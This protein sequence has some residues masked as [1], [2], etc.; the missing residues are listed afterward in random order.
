[1]TQT[2]LVGLDTARG[3]AVFGMMTAHIVLTLDEKLVDGRSSILFGVVAGVSLGLMTAGAPAGRAGRVVRAR[4][5]VRILL[6]ALLVLG[7]GLLLTALEPPVAVILD[8]YGALFILLLPLL[9]APRPVLLAVAAAAA[10]VGPVLVDLAFASLGG[11]VRGDQRLTIV[12]EWL[13][14]G[15]YPLVSWIAFPL[16]GLVVARSDLRRAATRA[17]MAGAGLVA[18]VCG[19]ALPGVLPSTTAEAHSGTTAEILG[20][21]GVALVVLAVTVQLLDGSGPL[22]RVLRVPAWPIAAVGSMPLTIYAIHVVAM[23]AAVHLAGADSGWSADYPGWLLPAN[24][25]G[26]IVVATA[27][28]LALRSGPIELLARRIT[29]QVP[30]PARPAATHPA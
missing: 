3:L 13:L 25:L 29:R 7:I 4:L 10:V 9:F 28:R 22:S 27:F 24:L 30:L 6:R 12:G 11:G 19:Y 20:S 5:R 23:A 2:R 1:M 21:G 8:E 15:Y 14:T 26:A 16:V 17:V 18:A